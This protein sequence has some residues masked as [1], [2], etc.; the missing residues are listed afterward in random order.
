MISGQAGEKL[1]KLGKKVETF[2]SEVVLNKENTESAAATL[3]KEE[4]EA[5]SDERLAAN[6]RA[7][8]NKMVMLK[9]VLNVDPED[10]DYQELLAPMI[11][12][13]DE[14]DLK[15]ALK[16]RRFALSRSLEM[17]L[18]KHLGAISEETQQAALSGKSIVGGETKK[19]AYLSE[20]NSIEDGKRIS[21]RFANVRKDTILSG[22]QEM[23]NA[24]ESYARDVKAGFIFKD[25]KAD[26]EAEKAAA[27]RARQVDIRFKAVESE[28]P[29]RKINPPRNNA[30][31][32]TLG[33][34]TLSMDLSGPKEECAKLWGGEDELCK[35]NALKNLL[36]LSIPEDA[37]CRTYNRNARG[38]LEELL[39]NNS[40]NIGIDPLANIGLELNKFI[41]PPLGQSSVNNSII[42]QLQNEALKLR[43]RVNK[44][45]FSTINM[46]LEKS[47]N[48]SGSG[49]AAAKATVSKQSSWQNVF[50]NQQERVVSIRQFTQGAFGDTFKL[51]GE[52][53]LKN[54]AIDIGHDVSGRVVNEATAKTLCPTEAGPCPVK[55][56][57]KYSDIQ[58]CFD[59]CSRHPECKSIVVDKSEPSCAFKTK[60]QTKDSPAETDPAAQTWYKAKEDRKHGGQGNLGIR[61]LQRFALSFF[62][63]E[64][65]GKEL[66]ETQKEK[67]DRDAREAR[68]RQEAQQG[69]GKGV[70]PP[71]TAEP[72]QQEDD[73]DSTDPE[74]WRFR[75]ANWILEDKPERTALVTYLRN[76]RNSPI[77]RQRQ[78]LMLQWEKDESLRE[79]GLPYIRVVDGLENG[80]VYAGDLLIRAARKV[81]DVFERCRKHTSDFSADPNVHIAFRKQ[82]SVFE[83]CARPR[84][85]ED[86]G[87]ARTGQERVQAII[88]AEFKQ[89][90]QDLLEINTKVVNGQ[91]VNPLWPLVA[92]YSAMEMMKM[93]YMHEPDVYEVFV[94]FQHFRANNKEN[95]GGDDPMAA[96]END[97][98]NVLADGNSFAFIKLE[99]VTDWKKTT[100]HGPH[101]RFFPKNNNMLTQLMRAELFERE[102]REFQSALQ[103]EEELAQKQVEKHSEALTVA[104][105]SLFRHLYRSRQLVP[106]GF[107]E[108]VSVGGDLV[109][110][111]GN[112]ARLENMQTNLMALPAE[113]GVQQP[114]AAASLNDFAAKAGRLSSPLSKLSVRKEN[115][116]SI[117]LTKLSQFL[118]ATLSEVFGGDRSSVERQIR[119]SKVTLAAVRDRDQKA[120]S[121]TAKNGEQNVNSQTEAFSSD[122]SSFAAVLQ[123]HTDAVSAAGTMAHIDPY[124]EKGVWPENKTAVAKN[125]FLLEQ[126]NFVKMRCIP[127]VAAHIRSMS[128]SSANNPRALDSVERKYINL[129]AEEDVEYLIWCVNETYSS[130]DEASWIGSVTTLQLSKAF[131][132]RQGLFAPGNAGFVHTKYDYDKPLSFAGTKN[133]WMAFA[134][135][136]LFAAFVTNPETAQEISL[137]KILEKKTSVDLF[138]VQSLDGRRWSALLENLSA[139]PFLRREALR[140][141]LQPYLISASEF[142]EIVRQE[143]M[144]AQED[145]EIGELAKRNQ[146][147]LAS[148]DFEQRKLIGATP[149]IE[150]MHSLV[151]MRALSRSEGL[152]KSQSTQLSVVGAGRNNGDSFRGGEKG[153]M[154]GP[155][156]VLN[157][158]NDVWGALIQL[159]ANEGSLTTKQLKP[160]IES[161][162]TLLCRI[163]TAGAKGDDSE[164]LVPRKRLVLKLSDMNNETLQTES[165]HLRVPFVDELC[166]GA[167]HTGMGLLVDID[168]YTEFLIQDP[169]ALLEGLHKMRG[170]LNEIVT[171]FQDS[172]TVAETP[173][174]NYR[175]KTNALSKSKEAESK[176]VATL[177]T[178]VKQN[179]RVEKEKRI[180]DSTYVRDAG[181]IKFF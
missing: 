33:E 4:E 3:R 101:S 172:I 23:E 66:R 27:N 173:K 148:S 77:V 106:Y 73:E 164:V 76:A 157:T 18:F 88:D 32:L 176:A 159:Q 8:R 26:L 116:S 47:N 136:P 52:G 97:S 62:F 113:P 154:V 78:L 87:D 58:V 42:T 104:E 111:I 155:E 152:G 91:Y 25:E 30:V 10:M 166:G 59:V 9:Q 75:F 39:Q 15:E 94:G 123:Q 83:N 80:F 122:T 14:K 57:K 55:Q 22:V 140:A 1:Q 125:Q 19:S 41:H 81:E 90:Y 130:D 40:F 156:L 179:E 103:S 161:L 50:F 5:E 43:N 54:K 100:A 17:C 109:A 16:F 178:S 134:N 138:L 160:K 119:Q 147:M 118:L 69:K 64:A 139:I 13:F 142:V 165:F 169:D 171:L 61:S 177:Q 49:S 74:S 92:E 46:S 20:G 144:F 107:K 31:V 84:P 99:N 44:Y 149:E 133:A 170:T 82:T 128:A 12:G 34:L 131:L 135:N 85:G 153:R 162:R 121:Q 29:P 117:E 105:D 70:S 21:E 7:N 28:K 79:R 37:V 174:Q 115:P 93:D 150:H 68:Q 45:R 86:W 108:A 110:E 132:S 129:E 24:D 163:E 48:A 65:D 67:K 175:G 53:T 167:A 72:E 158:V 89:M 151:Q 126:V 120:N 71:Q 127:E 168:E 63:E 146:A 114:A 141:K 56:I 95:T 51:L 35:S 36:N 102:Q 2:W 180:A 38:V 137:K 60:K 11:A 98:S 124:S 143:Q 145:N 181:S 6:S 112:R 96:A